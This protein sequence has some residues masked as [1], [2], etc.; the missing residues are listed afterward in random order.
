LSASDAIK[1][2]IPPE[3]QLNLPELT[4][5]ESLSVQTETVR[6][7]GRTTINLVEKLLAMTTNL[8]A[9]VTQLKTDNAV[10]SVQI[11]ELQ[12]LL[13]VELCHVEAAAR[14]MSS[15]AGV[16]SYN[17]ALAISQHQQ[18]RNV[19]TSKTLRILARG[20]VVGG[21]LKTPNNNLPPPISSHSSCVPTGHKGLS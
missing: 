5:N 9:E 18:E 15:Q 20:K 17:D 14:T 2:V 8:T 13:S 1:K 6:L 7:N 4:S 19:N 10:F 16:M 3:R 21:C 11:S 12:D